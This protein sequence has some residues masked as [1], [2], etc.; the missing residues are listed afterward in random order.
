MAKKD[1]NAHNSWFDVAQ[2]IE[3]DSFVSD[4]NHPSSIDGPIIEDAEVVYEENPNQ[5]I[6]DKIKYLISTIN[7][8]VLIIFVAFFL[9]ILVAVIAVL[10][11]VKKT[12]DSYYADIIVPEVVYMGESSNVYVKVHGKKDL[13]KTVTTFESEN[14]NIVAFSNKKLEGKEA[15]TIITPVQEGRVMVTAKSKLGSRKVADYAREVVVCPA[16]NA[17]LLLLKTISIIKDSTYTLPVDFGEVECSEDIEYISSDTNIMT[18]NENGTVTGVAPG[19]TTLIVKKGERSI[20]IPV[21]ITES[22]VVMESF[23]VVPTKVQLVPKQNIRLKVEYSPANA[24]ISTV[25]FYSSDD[26]IATVSEG[27]LVT[28]VAP[29]EAKISVA[30]AAITG[31]REVEVIV[32]KPKGGSQSGATE[33][34]LNKSEV[35]LVEG[36]SEKIIATVVPDDEENKTLKWATSDENVAS[37]DKNGVIYGNGEGN[38]VITVSTVNDVSRTINVKV[39]KMKTPTITASDNIGTG[40]WHKASYVLKFA[41]SEENAIYYYGTSADNIEQTGT[42]VTIS[43]DENVTYYVQGCKNVCT[44]KCEKKDKSDCK[45]VCRKG[46]CSNPATYTSKVDLVKPQV[47]NV[48]TTP[49]NGTVTAQ[50]TLK[51]DNS[52]IQRWCVTDNDEPSG[53]KWNILVTPQANPVI[54]YVATK[55]GAYYVFAMDT[56]GN[57][58]DNYRFRV[59]DI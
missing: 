40:G 32:N 57:I 28:G 54:P 42:Q 6:L 16:F 17:D 27:G 52:F 7:T 36:T 11:Y 38:C 14:E 10:V 44:K 48:V 19:T 58:S 56:A 4:V 3:E 2:T 50:I 35:H 13:D 33:I 37:V 29:G 51:D 20:T 1:D 31:I 43:K 26:K 25:K 8:R 15:E 45:K 49:G 5:T 59:D 9:V 24:T 55:L 12:N 18:V 41:N 53:C 30:T 23:N 21:I 39:V 22:L 47:L 46:V 34:N